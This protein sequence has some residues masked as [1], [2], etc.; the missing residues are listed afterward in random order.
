MEVSLAKWFPVQNF[1]QRILDDW[2]LLDDPFRNELAGSISGR[3][4]H[5][6]E[7]GE[8]RVICETSRLGSLAGARNERGQSQDRYEHHDCRRTSVT[9]PY[10][11]RLAVD[12][13]ACR[14]ISAVFRSATMA[15][16]GSRYIA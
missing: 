5:L 4:E 15:R 11:F 16:I 10:S 3:V 9:G 6:D 1:G 12:S 2:N 8:V 7:W 14:G 13:S